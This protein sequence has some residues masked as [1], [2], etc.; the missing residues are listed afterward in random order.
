MRP[1]LLLVFAC[2]A[3]GAPALQTVRIEN[4]TTRAIEELYVYPAGAASPGKSRGTLAPG[5]STQVAVK[6]GD[7]EVLAKSA[8][9]QVDETTRDRP[10]ANQELEV[11][12]PVEV[13]LYDAGSPP[14]GL[15]RPGVFGIEFVVRKPQPPP[16]P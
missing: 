4:H 2:A 14:P 9:V 15:N 1:A 7:I 5:A 6:P 8:K 16:E 13:V 10:E 3:C 12:G 11:H